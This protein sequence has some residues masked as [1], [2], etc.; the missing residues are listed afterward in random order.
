MANLRDSL[1]PS[2]DEL[3]SSCV[4]RL[5][6][7]ALDG[8]QGHEG[9]HESPSSDTNTNQG[10]TRDDSAQH[11]PA[12][13]PRSVAE[14][15][16]SM[17]DEDVSDFSIL[18]GNS[19]EDSGAMNDESVSHSQPSEDAARW[20]PNEG[21]RS[22]S[23]PLDESNNVENSVLPERDSSSSQNSNHSQAQD[24][25]R[26]SSGN[27]SESENLEDEVNVEV[28]ARAGDDIT[29]Y[30][31]GGD[32][33]SDISDDSDQS[34]SNDSG[35]SNMPGMDN[36]AIED[37]VSRICDEDSLY[38]YIVEG[39]IFQAL[40]AWYDVMHA[41]HFR[42]TKNSAVVQQRNSRL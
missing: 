21:M 30:D 39:T 28:P 40:L 18:H 17:N 19:S 41:V 8:Q 11:T 1:P 26:D 38:E 33:R 31:S 37:F 10:G 36:A 3:D 9:Q 2:R 24:R 12:D 14:T 22:P 29:A 16:E 25:D 23:S 27:A 15:S 35:G 6:R 32:W 5:A 42:S 4:R 13:S 20:N 34:R 7:E